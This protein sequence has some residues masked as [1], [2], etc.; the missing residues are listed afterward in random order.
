MRRNLPFM[1]GARARQVEL[2][3]EK[4]SLLRSGKDYPFRWGELLSEVITPAF[5][6]NPPVARLKD[7]AAT[8]FGLVGGPTWVGGN[9]GHPLQT[10]EEIGPLPES[11]LFALANCLIPKEV[12]QMPL[13]E[14]LKGPTVLAYLLQKALGQG[15]DTFHRS[16]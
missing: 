6:A 8:W 1:L 14:L 4:E 13:H 11:E 5:L 9:I 7:G 10:L 16:N 3:R 12:K 15:S 2:L